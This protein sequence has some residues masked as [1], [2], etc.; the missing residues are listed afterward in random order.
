MADV[1]WTITPPQAQIATQGIKSAEVLL[2]TP[3][4]QRLI[5]T[6]GDAGREVV[7]KS[8][9]VYGDSAGRQ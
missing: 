4:G 8:V 5:D 1:P 7:F 3:A 9:E 6:A 2:Q